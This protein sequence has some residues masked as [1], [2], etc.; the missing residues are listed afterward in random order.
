LSTISGARRRKKSLWYRTASSTLSP[1]GN[2]SGHSMKLFPTRVVVAALAGL[3]LAGCTVQ[4]LYAPAPRPGA[5]QA[6]ALPSIYIE[7]VDDRVGQEVRNALIFMMNGGSGQPAN[8]AYTLS[9]KVTSVKENTLIVQ[10]TS[11]DGE[12]TTRTVM[13]TANYELR[14]ASDD[15]SVARRRA[16]A[17]TSY[18]V[19]Y[20]EF[21]NTR[22][23]RDAEN[24]AAREVAGQLR[25][26]IAADLS[27]AGAF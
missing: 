14:R 15:A 20:Q 12:P 23:A 3:T 21:A 10:T 22:A 5:A 9:L 8:P 1:D 17:S 6:A 16:N 27:R 2:G 24:R 4:P 13:V 19:S 25:A 7:P 18:D 11:T 26:L